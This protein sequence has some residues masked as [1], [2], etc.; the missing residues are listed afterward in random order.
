MEIP[1]IRAVSSD[2]RSSSPS[3]WIALRV[4]YGS[5]SMAKDSISARFHDALQTSV[6][7]LLF[8]LQYLVVG[9]LLLGPIALISWAI[10]RVV[11]RGRKSAPATSST[12]AAP[13]APST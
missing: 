1:M 5:S 2:D 7:G 11:R 3:N 9:V 6:K 12:P 4:P 10:W 8:V 13:P